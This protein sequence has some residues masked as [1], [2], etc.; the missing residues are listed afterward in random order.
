MYPS[1]MNIH[2][3][4][5]RSRNELDSTIQI[6]ELFHVNNMT[7]LKMCRTALFQQH[8]YSNACKQCMSIEKMYHY[9][10]LIITTL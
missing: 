6:H 3:K 5:R 8:F 2:E 4:E 7:Q 9:V 1:I 10:A